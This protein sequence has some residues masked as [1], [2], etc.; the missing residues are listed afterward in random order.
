MTTIQDLMN[1]IEKVENDALDKNM[2]LS[3]L[4]F[5]YL[6]KEKEQIIDAYNEGWQYGFLSESGEENVK[7]KNW[8][9]YYKEVFN[10]SNQADA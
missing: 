2:L 6:P 5:M 3:V 10:D 9:E 7:T 4:K 8:E 1:T